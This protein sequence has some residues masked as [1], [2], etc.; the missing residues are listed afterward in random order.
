MNRREVIKSLGAVSLHALYPSVITTFLTSCKTGENEKQFI[1]FNEDER[2]VLVAIIDAILPATKTK[3][4]SQAG[5]HLFLDEVFAVCLNDDQKKLIE[6]GLSTFVFQWKEVDDKIKFLKKTDQQAF[7][8]AEDAA[9]FKFLKQFT[10]IGFFTSEEGTTKAGDYQ[11]IPDKFTGEVSVSDAALG[12]SVT[13]L[14]F[15]L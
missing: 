9:W 11:K 2:E 10:L 8:G 5:V 13:A 14:R 12:H 4:A 7:G 1:F 15:S 6:D 3:S